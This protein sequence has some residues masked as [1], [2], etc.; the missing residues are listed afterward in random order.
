M[1]ISIDWGWDLAIFWAQPQI[2]TYQA[3]VDTGGIWSKKRSDSEKGVLVN[4]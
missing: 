2:P 4:G 1:W 3:K